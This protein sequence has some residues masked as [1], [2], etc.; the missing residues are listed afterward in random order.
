[1]MVRD[2]VDRDVVDRYVLRRDKVMGKVLIRRSVFHRMDPL[3]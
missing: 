3:R 2:V 1:M